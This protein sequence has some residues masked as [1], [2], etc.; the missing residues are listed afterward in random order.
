MVVYAWKWSPSLFLMETKLFLGVGGEGYPKSRNRNRK[1]LKIG[2]KPF[3]IIGQDT[4]WT[5]GKWVEKDILSPFFEYRIL[6]SKMSR[7]EKYNF[8][9]N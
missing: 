9:H 3:E 5:I 4:T 2:L 7:R 6:Y 1:G 8:S